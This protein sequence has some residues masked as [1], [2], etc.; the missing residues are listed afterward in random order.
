L[1]ICTEKEV[2]RRENSLLER[3]NLS[4]SLLCDRDDVRSGV[5]GYVTADH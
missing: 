4:S 1:Q 5:C 2:S 3:K